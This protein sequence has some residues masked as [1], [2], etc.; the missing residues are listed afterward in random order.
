MALIRTRRSRRAYWL[1]PAV[2]TI[3]MCCWAPL[4][5]APARAQAQDPA[6]TDTGTKEKSEKEE[7]QSE[8]SSSNIPEVL[9]WGSRILNMDIRRSK[10]DPQPYVIFD[11]QRIEQSAATNIE[12]FLKR[13]LSQNA[14]A[15]TNSQKTTDMGNSSNIN[16]RG[17]G[18]GQTLILIDGRRA[19]VQLDRFGGLGQADLNGIPLAAVERIEVLPTTAAGIYG[20]GATGGVVNVILRRDYDGIDTRINFEDSLKH[21]AAGRRV[22]IAAGFDF[23]DGRTNVLLAGSFS[24]QNSIA[25]RDRDFTQRY[26]DRVLANSG[27]DYMVFDTG[28]PPLGATTNIRSIDISQNLTLKD[29]TPLNSPITFVPP[30][31]FGPFDDPISHFHVPDGGQA[32][33]ANAGKYNLE[34]ANNTQGSL[35][36]GGKF[37]LQSEPTVTSVL[38]TVRRQF[39]PR[40]QGFLDVMDSKNDHIWPYTEV[41]DIFWRIRADQPTNPFNQDIYVTFPFNSSDDNRRV[42]IRNT[43]ASAGLIWQLGERWMGEA[44]Y[45]WNQTYNTSVTASGLIYDSY[46]G[47]WES[48]T[49]EKVVNQET[50]IQFVPADRPAYTQVIRDLELYPIDLDQFGPLGYH[51]TLKPAKVTLQDISLR[52]GGPIFSLPAGDVSLTGLLEYRT[53]DMSSSTFRH[54]VVRYNFTPSRSEKVNSVYL[55]ARLPLVSERNAMPAVRSLELQLAARRDEYTINGV[56]SNFDNLVSLA[57]IDS[58]EIARAT[59]KLSS[60]DPTIA[61]HYQPLEDLA[62]RASYGTGFTPPNVNQLTPA[63]GAS[64]FLDPRRGNTFQFIPDGFT[65]L[66]GNPDLNPEE[67][68][69]L[70]LGLI[71]TPRFIPRA[72]LSL[73]YTKIEKTDNIFAPSP[74]FIVDFEEVYP[75]RVV[76]GPNL[77]NDPAGFAGPVTFIDI[78]ALN[79]LKSEVEAYDL[80]LDYDLQMQS[81]GNIAFSL[82]STWTTHFR[83]Q[84]APHAPLLEYVGFHPR[85]GGAPLKQRA[86]LSATWRFQN[87]QVGWDTDYYHSY[88][89]YAATAD[90][91]SIAHAI[92]IQGAERIPR[93]IYHNLYAGI[94]FGELGSGSVFDR[95]LGNTGIAIGVKNVFNKAPPF[96]AFSFGFPNSNGYYSAFGDPRLASYYVT[97]KHAF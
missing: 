88:L 95:V 53:Q 70:S 11:H 56:T 52:V 40:I 48:V 32:L 86:N 44:D 89:A 72:R 17:L 67:S 84:N 29:G 47:F 34:W 25:I 73:D 24:H 76:R 14:T 5:T 37:A 43:R 59:G 58:L 93:Q 20:G 63:L 71:F 35:F 38:A 66:G 42:I 27:N 65:R 75:D 80:Q 6:R 19:P 9:V 68:E 16:L 8:E 50:G 12:D 69:N 79:L 91:A 57:E 39:T 45:V 51:Y 15:D 23:E 61:L 83:Q 74:Q 97:L 78:T 85:D 96:D 55:E 64:S 22:D 10:D 77:P 30:G 3:A 18:T 87:W 4:F 21:D 81:L 82:L 62:I 90:T 36:R 13:R 49:G 33:V 60:I 7:P 2:L 28:L 94:S 54:N 31:Y 92:R 1:T 26:R 46:V 41:G